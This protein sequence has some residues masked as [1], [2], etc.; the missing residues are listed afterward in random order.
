MKKQLLCFVLTVA[1]MFAMMS[2][3]V[4]AT[5]EDSSSDPVIVDTSATTESETSAETTSATESSTPAETTSAT[6]SS[7][8]TETTSATE[9]STAEETTS[10]TESSTPEETTSA[11]ESS[12]AEET[13]SATESSTPEETTSATESGTSEETTGESKVE[14]IVYVA[15]SNGVKYTS[16]QEAINAATDGVETTVTLLQSVTLV[17][18]S[19]EIPP[20]KKIVLD[21]GGYTLTGVPTPEFLTPEYIEKEKGYRVIGVSQ[22]YDE[23]TKATKLDENGNPIFAELTIQNGTVVCDCQQLQQGTTEYAIDTIRNHGNLTIK[24]AKIINKS[25]P[26]QLGYAVDNHSGFASATVA[27]ENSKIEALGSGY[28]DGVRQYDIAQSLYDNNLIIDES[29]DVSTIWVQN[30]PDPYSLVKQAVSKAIHKVDNQNHA[31]YFSDISGALGVAAHPGE[32]VIVLKDCSFSQY[33]AVQEGVILDL[34]GKIVSTQ[35]FLYCEGDLIDSSD[36]KGGVIVKR[37]LEVAP[38]NSYIPLYDEELGGYRFFNCSVRFGRDAVT[39]K[40]DWSYLAMLDFT[41]MNAYELLATGETGLTLNATIS[42][43]ENENAT[44]TTVIDWMLATESMIA[45]ANEQLSTSNAIKQT[46]GVLLS[47]LNEFEGWNLTVEI[48]LESVDVCFYRTS[49]PK[50]T[51][52]PVTSTTT[53]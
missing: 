44:E 29:S 3:I 52:I 24:D 13:T 25:I 45:Y 1:M 14:N 39:H 40:P 5:G 28:C 18:E 38:N 49:G 23:A 6:E 35:K 31:G 46:V 19:I 22:L 53:N 11:T 20:T 10:A 7:T 43:R 34:N 17:G 32:T 48:Y 37:Y 12:T 41:N 21:L 47:G 16:I 4:V 2:P 33:I 9:S 15:E 50:S 36:G 42:L 30:V 8:A 51:T 27:L 26:G